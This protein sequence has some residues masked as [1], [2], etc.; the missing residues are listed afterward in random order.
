MPEGYYTVKTGDSPASIAGDV[1]GDQRMFA[2]IMKANGGVAL[3]PGMRIV[4]PRK[5]ETPFVSNELAAAVGLATSGQV[6]DA[7]KP[8]SEQLSSYGNMNW[9]PSQAMGNQ[10]WAQAHARGQ[11]GNLEN[12]RLP[13]SF[14][15]SGASSAVNAPVGGIRGVASG[16][17]MGWNQ[18]IQTNVKGGGQLPIPPNITGGGIGTPPPQ[19]NKAR[20]ESFPSAYSA[21]SGKGAI[22]LNQRTQATPNFSTPNYGQIFNQNATTRGLMDAFRQA[23][24]FASNIVRGVQNSPLFKGNAPMPKYG[25]ENVGV[26]GNATPAVSPAISPTPSPDSGISGAA[27]TANNNITAVVQ[28]A[29]PTEWED[30]FR[31]VDWMAVRAGLA[32]PPP[33]N[34]PSYGQFSPYYQEGNQGASQTQSMNFGLM[35]NMNT[36]LASG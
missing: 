3:K 7:Y 27:N 23:Q 36:R 29:T 34:Y 26:T 15:P 2:E 24:T 14:V 5:I 20:R 33:Y 28:N 1:Y 25:G 11:A 10:E 35:G 6:A 31:N 17:G 18:P 4:L 30:V 8:D 21:Q 32:V 22:G 12:G 16:Q 19:D 9:T 13:G